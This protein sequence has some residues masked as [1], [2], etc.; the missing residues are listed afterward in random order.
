[1]NLEQCLDILG[2][3]RLSRDTHGN[4]RLDQ[5]LASVDEIVA[6]ARKRCQQRLLKAAEH[7]EG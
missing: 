7:Q 1:M 3:I 6:A 2:P 5:R 4:L